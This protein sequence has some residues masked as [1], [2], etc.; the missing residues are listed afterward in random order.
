M[1]L[2]NRAGSGG[3]GEY[4]GG[5]GG[6]QR[7]KPFGDEKKTPAHKALWLLRGRRDASARLARRGIKSKDLLTLRVRLPN[8]RQLCCLTFGLVV[9]RAAT[10]DGTLGIYELEQG[11][12]VRLRLSSTPSERQGTCTSEN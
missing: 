9:R 1:S 10:R 8:S 5:L 3:Q 11:A 6:H 7:L 2:R 4:R 12:A